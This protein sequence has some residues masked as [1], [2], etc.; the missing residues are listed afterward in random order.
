[1]SR[2]GTASFNLMH[3]CFHTS[4]WCF[5]CLVLVIASGIS[6]DHHLFSWHTAYSTPP[7]SAPIFPAASSQS[8]CTVGTRVMNVL[9]NQHLILL[10][11]GFWA[12][13]VTAPCFPLTDRLSHTRLCLV[14]MLHLL[15]CCFLFL[16]ELM[17]YFILFKKIY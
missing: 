10:A 9:K 7:V 14:T 11:S 13:L 4:S 17:H 3:K 15:L 2:P 12:T 1:M 8:Y 5:P 16:T 6:K